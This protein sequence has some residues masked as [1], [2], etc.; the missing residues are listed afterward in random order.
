MRPAHGPAHGVYFVRPAASLV[1]A[2]DACL[3]PGEP[4]LRAGGRG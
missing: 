2:L 1:G 3:A 4:L